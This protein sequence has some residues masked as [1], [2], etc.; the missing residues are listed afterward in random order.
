MHVKLANTKSNNAT[1]AYISIGYEK[2]S[3]TRI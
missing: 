2:N 1:K 3:Q